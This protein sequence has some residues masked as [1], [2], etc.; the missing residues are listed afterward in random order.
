MKRRAKVSDVANEVGVSVATVSRTFN[1]P[2]AVRDDVR[3]RVLA[4]AR[5]LGYSPHPA[6]K[7]LRMQRTHIVGAVVPTLDYAIY[8]RMMN[9]FQ[10]RM[11][12]AGYM[13]FMLAAGFDNSKLYDPVHQLVSRGT[14]GLLVVGKI[15]D[16]LLLRFLKERHIPTVLTYSYL[17]EEPFPS[18]GFDNY[19]SMRQLI[20]YLLLLGH[21]DIVMIS[22]IT[23]G[24]DRQRSRAGAFQ[25]AVTKSGIAKRCHALERPYSL[26]EGAA[27]VRLIRSEYPKTTAVMCAS[28]VL[29]FGVLSE[30][31]KLNIHVPNDM[32]ITGYDNQDFSALLD[33]S[34]TTVDVPAGDMGTQSAEALLAAMTGSG[35]VASVKL[36]TNLIIRDSTAPTH[37]IVS[38]LAKEDHG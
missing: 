36:K 9:K 26:Y 7:A 34:L 10:E 3:A 32:V 15:E 28:D 5:S 31:K 8:A 29:A 18:V 1:D 22:G 6:A 35:K 11:N 20:E 33:P 37:G 16:D 38:A 30:C 12:T 24:N 2:K 21:R 27:A 4:V 23:R 14:D 25:D 17:P 19:E 13:V